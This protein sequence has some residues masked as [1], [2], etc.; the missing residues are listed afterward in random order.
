[1]PGWLEKDKPLNIYKPRCWRCLKDN[2]AAHKSLAKTIGKEEAFYF[3]PCS[4]KLRGITKGK[5]FCEEKEDINKL[6]RET[7]TP[8]ARIC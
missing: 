1:M 5:L 3:R 6:P 4:Y 8:K 2:H 7:C